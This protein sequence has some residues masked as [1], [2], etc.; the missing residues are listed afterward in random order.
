MFKINPFKRPPAAPSTPAPDKS[1]QDKIPCYPFTEEGIRARAQQVYE[2]RKTSGLAGTPEGD[3]QQAIREL[4][5][6]RSPFGKFYQWTG[7]GQKKGWD[8]LTSIS[9]PLIVFMGGT[10]FTYWNNQQQ[11]RIAVD[12]REQDLQIAEYR[13]KQDIKLADD[14]AK[15]DTL[16]NYLDDMSKS[17][18]GGLLD[19]APGSKAFVV[20]QSRTVLALQSLDKKR[21]QLVIQF[22]QASGL[23][24]V[25]KDKDTQK[26]LEKFAPRN[27]SKLPRNAKLGLLYRTQMKNANLANSDLSGAKL[28]G[29]WLQG[30]NFGCNPSDSKER[31]DCSDL[32]YVDL[33]GAILWDAYLGFALLAAA[34]LEDANFWNADL[35]GA[36]LT[37]ANLTGANLWNAN[38]SD[39][40]LLGTNLTG[41]KKLTPQQLTG[42]KAP[43]LCVVRLP[44]YITGIYPYRDC[45]RLPEE[46]VKREPTTFPDLQKAQRVVN[47]WRQHQFE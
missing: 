43:L 12:N 22:L 33:R 16:V 37:G 6:E 10:L 3:W 11:Q 42:D 23:N 36:N 25:G 20:A 24:E 1:T 46:L 5:W 40:I 15:Q 38:L 29:A 21:Q 13:R 4:R 7:L 9:L 35:T 45:D 14:K 8:L 39:A 31:E 47:E 41:S 34:N 18:E 28:I 19:A 27:L 44:D 2:R 30:A 17:I 32:N 26:F